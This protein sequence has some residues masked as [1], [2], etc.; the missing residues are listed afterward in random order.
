MKTLKDH[1]ERARGEI[2]EPKTVKLKSAASYG[3]I[4][5]NTIV[6]SL[7]AFGFILLGAYY[8]VNYT[9]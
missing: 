4:L 7:L 9:K 3:L 8:Y 2:I 1:A 6:I 5:V